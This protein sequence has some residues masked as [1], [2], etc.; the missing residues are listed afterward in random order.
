MDVT[1]AAANTQPRPTRFEHACIPGASARQ[2]SWVAPDQWPPTLRKNKTRTPY[3]VAE[4]D[5]TAFCKNDDVC[6]N[7]DHCTKHTHML[8]RRRATCCEGWNMN[9]PITDDS[10]LLRS[11]I[12]A[13]TH[14][15]IHLHG[16][17][18]SS[19]DQGFINTRYQQ[20]THGMPHTTAA[21]RQATI[22]TIRATDVS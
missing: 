12:A 22:T 11:I 4:A 21:M 2:D 9:N 16:A 13:Q 1:A 18:P 3:P 6:S 14:T 10:G 20:P 17:C 19:G 7:N 5:R 15:A 8:R